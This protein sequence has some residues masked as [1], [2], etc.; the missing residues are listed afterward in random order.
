MATV[1]KRRR[2]VGHDDAGKPVYRDDGYQVRYVDPAGVER[3]R[4]GFKKKAD[5]D[6]FATEIEHRKLSGMYVDPAA[7]RVTFREYA[8][9]WR[10]VQPH[11]AGTVEQLESRLRLHVYPAIG[12]RPI[13]AIRPTELQALVRDRATHMAPATLKNVVLWVGTIF[14]AAVNDRIITTSPAMK[15]KLPTPPEHAEDRVVILENP[16][17]DALAAALPARLAPMVEVGVSAGLRSG[18]V[19]GLTVDRVDFLRRIITVDRQLVTS[20]GCGPALGPPKT[21]ASRRTIPVPEGLTRALAAH[22]AAFP[23]GEQGL[24]FTNP[25]GS[26]IRRN[27]WGETWARAVA[28]AEL[29]QGT[30]FHALRHTYAS[31]LISAGCS[32]KVVQARLGHATAQ[33]T[34]DTYS[35][36]WPDDEDKTRS[37]VEL[38]R[39]SSWSDFGPMDAAGDALD[40]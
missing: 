18:E 35:H 11:R 8:E 25:D 31:A 6:R 14:R 7:G 39:G 36:L 22:L 21:R 30:R 23:A 12:D 32:V 24:I 2:K 28:T 9:A 33:E 13:S 29:E 19:L 3:R 34:L 4:G 1:S 17:V 5:A 37:A 26:P 16:A 38:L 10:K 20:A 27:R 40:G 15:L